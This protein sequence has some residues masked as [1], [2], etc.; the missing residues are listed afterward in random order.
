M[1]RLFLVSSAALTVLCLT[2]C[3]S[4]PYVI[5]YTPSSTPQARSTPLKTDPNQG[6]KAALGMGRAPADLGFDEKKFD[7]CSF[8]LNGENGCGNQYFT[9]V[10]FQLLCR[11]S[12]GTVSVINNVQPIVSDRVTWQ[13]GG[14]TGPTQTD[15][16]GYGQFSL[17]TRRSNKNQRLILRIGPQFVGFNVSEVTK[18][19]LP[20]NFC[21]VSRV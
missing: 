9:V 16:N 19:V 6:L 13:L 21:R 7:P 11:D 17:I 4:N 18:I 10:H 12:E 14:I 20:K 5:P 1:K 3:S 2:N 8:G 15:D